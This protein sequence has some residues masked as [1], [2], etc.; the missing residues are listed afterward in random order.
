MKIFRRLAE[1]ILRIVTHRF[2][3]GWVLTLVYFTFLVEYVKW[4]MG[5]AAGLEGFIKVLIFA[6]IMIL[7][8]RI[9]NFI[10]RVFSK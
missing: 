3:A 5:N 7:H 2:F 6:V 8:R 4:C 1:W 9:L 10:D